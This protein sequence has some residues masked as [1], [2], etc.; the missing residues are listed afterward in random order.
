MDNYRN[1]SWNNFQDQF[2]ASGGA[3]AYMK[4]V[5]AIMSIGL[6][7]TGITSW[8]IGTN[9][10][11]MQMIF[12]TLGRI[13]FFIPLIFV[14]ALSFG[15]NKMNYATASIVFALYAL[16]NGVSLSAIFLVYKLG[17][18]AYV[19][20]VTTGMFASMALIG[21]TTK[22]DL[23][24]YSSFL[25][26]GLMGLFIA[27]IIN[28][29]FQSDLFSFIKAIF[30][31]IIFCGLTAYDSQKIIEMG[32]EADEQNESTQKSALM[33]ALTLYLDFINLFLYLLR[34]LGN[35]KGD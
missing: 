29:F 1:N 35:R 28:I 11:L 23:T 10:E 34:L 17:S 5:Y 30:G 8:Y 31:V 13:T 16:S 27:G 7:I 32:R 24:K 18:I 14:L 4:Q 20:F 22:I 33:G 3:N 12:G 25:Y 19:F 15:I 2:I 6:A 26:M 9:M 21:M